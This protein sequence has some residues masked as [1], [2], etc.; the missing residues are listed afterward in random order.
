MKIKDA[1]ILKNGAYAGYIYKN[2]KWIWRLLKRTQKGQGVK[3]IDKF[4]NKECIK[5]QNIQQ[6]KNEKYI[7]RVK[8]KNKKYILKVNPILQNTLNQII[9][10]KYL[11][12]LKK[13]NICYNFIDVY[14]ICKTKNIKDLL[15]IKN[16]EYKDY[17]IIIYP[18]YNVLCKNYK[19]LKNIKHLQ[20]FNNQQDHI[21]F[22][23][24]WCLYVSYY[25]YKFVHGD[26]YNGREHNI[27]YNIKHT[28]KK[29]SIYKHG[30]HIWK[31]E[32]KDNSYPYLILFDFDY[33]NFT[34]DKYKLTSKV[35]TL[36]IKNYPL[37]SKKNTNMKRKLDIAGIN[38]ILQNC[39]GFNGK[40]LLEQVNVSENKR[41]LNGLEKYKISVKEYKQLDKSEYK[42][43]ECI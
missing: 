15:G 34:Y 12:K 14:S 19:I 30:A 3:D 4:L 10:L 24:K 39:L 40:N 41:L 6:L 11:L 36:S 26:I 29:Y 42:L 17:L 37:G 43:L 18:E 28:N 31:F 5:C 7:Y 38:N 9:I 27:L 22:Q 21:I 25:L 32:I 33:S 16:D 13:K 20:I 8:I 2:K 35:P 23:C 1:R